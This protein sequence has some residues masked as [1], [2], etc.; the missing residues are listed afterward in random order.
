MFYTLSEL[1]VI[2]TRF[3]IKFSTFSP[4]IHGLFHKTNSQLS[5][6]Y[7]LFLAISHLS[8]AQFWLLNCRI[9]EI[10]WPLLWN[11]F[12]LIKL[13]GFQL[14]FGQINSNFIKI[15]IWLSIYQNTIRINQLN[16]I[17]GC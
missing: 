5:N 13:L 12:T 3:P 4:R 15:W 11:I 16:Q 9:E 1:L 8:Q 6:F 7:F 2:T 10:M 17:L 14:I